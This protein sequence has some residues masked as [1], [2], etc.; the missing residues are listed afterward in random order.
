MPEIE[1]WKQVYDV[2]AKEH[3][4]RKEVIKVWTP[5]LVLIVKVAE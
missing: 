1:D 2:R 4:R 5:N 3:Q